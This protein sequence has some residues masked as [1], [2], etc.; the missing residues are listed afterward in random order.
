MFSRVMALV[1]AAALCGCQFFSRAQA[2]RLRAIDH[3]VAHVSTVPANRGAAVEIFVRE[4]IASASAAAPRPVVLMVHGG[5]SPSILAFDVE[6]SSYSW[7]SYLARAG[8]DVFAMDL[9]GYGQSARPE[10]DDACN[11]IPAQQKVLIPETLTAPCKPSYPYQLVN[12]R[13][14]HDE[15][16]RVI[17]YIRRLRGVST[18]SLL[19]WSGGGYRIGTYASE[20]PDK[21]DKLVIYASSNYARDNSS[22][23]PALPQPGSPVTIESR[24]VAEER[25]LPFARCA[26]Q[27]EPGMPERIWQLSKQQDPVG[28]A[29]GPGVLRAPTRTYWGWNREEAKRVKAPALVMV[30]E[31]DRL[32]QSNRELY[33]DLGAERKVFLSVA[34]GSHFLLWEKNHSLLHAASRLWL[35]YGA[36]NGATRGEFR[37]AL[38]E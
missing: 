15:L 28:M 4:K 3:R 29:W 31:F 34:C 22:A 8:F 2:P 38:V 30:G 9:T 23:A 36:F 17:E 35:T 18:V 32:H 11:V 16:D 13:S 25:W 14:E 6:Y 26:D 10:M 33:D 7:M 1:A 24:R 20:H 5:I 27:I 21:L 12:R 19:G 37:M